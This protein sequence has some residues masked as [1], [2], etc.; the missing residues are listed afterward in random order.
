MSPPRDTAWR[1]GLVEQLVSIRTTPVD[2]GKVDECNTIKGE[3]RSP[4]GAPDLAFI[5][6]WSAAWAKIQP[7]VDKLNTIGDNYDTFVDAGTKSAKTQ[8]ATIMANYKK[9]QAGD[10]QIPLSHVFDEITQFIS[11]ANAINTAA[12]KGNVDKLKSE[13]AAAAKEIAPYSVQISPPVRQ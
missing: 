1:A 4:S 5:A 11:F 2:L 9:R 8:F 3:N 12:S 10:D 13:A 6:C 7:E